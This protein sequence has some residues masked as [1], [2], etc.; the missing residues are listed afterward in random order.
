MNRRI[1]LAARPKGDPTVECF[2]LESAPV[3]VL[4]AGEV[5]LRTLYLSLD[6]Y[7]RGRMS[8]APSYAPP[9]AVG[10]VMCGGTVCRVEQSLAPEFKPGEVV[11]ARTGWQELAA[12]PAAELVK[13]DPSA[14]PLSWYLGVLGMPGLT[15]YVGLLDLGQPKAGDTVV[16]AAATGPVGSTVGQI[17]KLKGCRVVGIAGGAEKCAYVVKELGF[18]AC[19]DH[20]APD[21]AK[22]MAGAC[23]KGIDVYFENVGGD[24]LLAVLPL[25]NVGGRVPV[26]GTVA[27]YSLT[28]LPVG[29]DHLPLIMR[30]ILVKRLKVQGFII[31]DHAHRQ[32]DF[33]RDVGEWVRQ[34]RIR[35]RE[36]VVEGL[37]QAPQAFLRMLKGGNFGKLVVRI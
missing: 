32:S 2:R 19:I 15:A 11:L 20:R 21:L 4:Q 5:L 18:D 3:P 12:A 10:E 1:V 36:D 34:G 29:R 33:L 31:F 16:V 7:M 23:P 22:R 6:P 9:V 28:E 24:V 35:Y 26:C 25:L 17:A 30:N 14:A 27:W 13:L 37:E 8:D